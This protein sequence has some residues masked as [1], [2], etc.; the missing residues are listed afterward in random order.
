MASWM[1]GWHALAHAISSSN[2]YPQYHA[3]VLMRFRQILGLN[4]H[5]A[6][7]VTCM[8]FNRKCTKTLS[9]APCLVALNM[10]LTLYLLLF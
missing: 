9:K 8:C 1:V 10:Y 4:F 7:H 3:R 5:D 2:P 6:L